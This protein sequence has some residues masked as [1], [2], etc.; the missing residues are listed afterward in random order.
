MSQPAL[1]RTIKRVEDVLGVSLFERTTRTVRATEAGRE[2][3]A[4][5]QRVSNDLRIAAEGLRE[6]A[7]QQRGHVVVSSIMSAANGVLPGV[8]SDYRRDHPGIEIRIMDGVHGSVID[9][10]RSGAADFGISYIHDIPDNVVA[11]RLGTG[12]FDLVA[13]RGADISAAG[14]GAIPFEALS[15]LDLISMP[16]EAQTRRIFD[17]TAAARGVR[18]RHAVTV[19]QIPTML[20][21]VRAGVGVGLAP[22]AS[23][24]GELGDDLIRISVVEPRIEMDIGLVT[25]GERVLSP[26][27]RG[28]RDMIVAGWPI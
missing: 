17:A 6:L 14:S 21:L 18:L 10:V 20:S 19:S 13:L 12:S 23:I 22:S 25:G 28:L 7:Q 26:A 3:I 11:T 9:D 24:S 1:T 5:A 2:F 8:V 27:A 4:V 15:R 16:P